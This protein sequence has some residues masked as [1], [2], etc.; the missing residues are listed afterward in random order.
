MEGL[1]R[2]ISPLKITTAL[3]VS[4][5]RRELRR[6]HRKRADRAAIRDEWI[7]TALQHTTAELVQRDGRIRHWAYIV[8]VT[9][10][11][12]V[13]LLADGVTVHHAFFDRRFTP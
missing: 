4:V 2:V 10:Y 12:R 9:R 6:V 7:L 11:L 3:I 13:V 1:S 8:E 5:V